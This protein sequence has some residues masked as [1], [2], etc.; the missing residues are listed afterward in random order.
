MAHPRVRDRSRIPSLRAAALVAGAALV[1]AGLLGGCST[2]RTNSD[3][4]ALRSS[5]DAAN[6]AFM[7]AFARKDAPSLGLVYADDARAYPPGAPLVDGRAAIEAMWTG[8]L[9]L[10]VAAVRLETAE[11]QGGDDWAWESGRYTLTGTDGQTVETGK[12]VVVWKHDEAG[13]K[14]FRDIWN[15]DAPATAP[16]P[17]TPTTPPDGSGAPGVP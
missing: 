11:L 3:P 2:S 16:A 14:I 12:Y 1:A 17:E 5:I 8:M 7:D 9:A 6:K 4:A 10:P 15:S 13:W